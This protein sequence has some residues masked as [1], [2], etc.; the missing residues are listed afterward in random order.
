M[1]GAKPFI[2]YV[3][4]K[5]QLLPQILPHVPSRFF[6]YCEPFVGGGALFWKLATLEKLEGKSVTLAD[7]NQRLVEL[8]EL[9]RDDPD[10][11][12]GYLQRMRALYDRSPEALYY[13]VRDVWNSGV[14]T[15]GMLVFLKQT[16]FNGLLRY[17]RRGQLNMAW[18][19]RK[20]PA[21]LDEENIRSCHAVL[22]RL[23]VTLQHRDVFEVLATGPQSGWLYYFDPPYYGTFD[24][25]DSDGFG[26]DQQ[27]ALIRA[28]GE[29]SRAGAHVLYSNALHPQIEQWIAE[30][31][32]AA[33]V[34][35]VLA[36]D[37]INRDGAG[38][39]QRAEVLAVSHARMVRQPVRFSVQTDGVGR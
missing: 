14:Q 4:G 8:Y 34:E 18:G 7:G 23:G 11:L 30:L 21:I 38:R 29:F 32:P 39:G 9:V 6:G 36:R 31:W 25:Y 19:H 15:P 28:C 27:R 35:Q 12:I 26:A 17:N 2:K 37:K 13:R 20:N 1:V 22:K 5:T 24:Q 33:R 16:S 10:Y 3:G